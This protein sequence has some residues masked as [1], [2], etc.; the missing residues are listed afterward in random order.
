M[1]ES[2]VGP[3]HGETEAFA[4]VGSR[5]KL[6]LALGQEAEICEVRIKLSVENSHSV[7]LVPLEHISSVASSPENGIFGIRSHS[8]VIFPAFWILNQSIVLDELPSNDENVIVITREIFLGLICIDEVISI[9]SME[10]VRCGHI[11]RVIMIP[12]TARG[13]HIFIPAHLYR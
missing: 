10:D 9:E 3:Y 8:I 7:D 4:G 11:H 6:V 12:Q 13:L 2:G 1:E 5:L